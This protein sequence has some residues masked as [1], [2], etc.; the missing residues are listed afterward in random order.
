[1]ACA[2]ELYKV[3]IPFILVEKEQAVGGLAKTYK[4]GKFRT[5]NGPHRFY[6]QNKYLYDFIEDLVQEKWI[7]VNRFTRFYIKGKF[8]KYPVEILEI[9]KKIGFVNIVLILNDYAWA[10]VI[11]FR[12]K[13][14]NF[15]Q[16][17]LLTFGKRLAYLNVINFS[18]KTWGVSTEELSIDFASQRIKGVTIANILKT[19]LTNKNAVKSMIDQ[20]YYPS[21]GSGYVYECIKKRIQKDNRVEL[22]VKAQKIFTKDKQISKVLLSNGETVQI[23]NLVS[24]MPITEFVQLL[25]IPIPAV[26][27]KAIKKLRYR[28]QVYLFLTLNKPQVTRDQWIYFPDS[29]I[30][31]SRISEMKNFSKEMAPPNKTS[32]FVEYFCWYDD[33]V[34]NMSKKELSQLTISWLV[35]LGFIKEKDVISTYL[36]KQKDCYPV[37]DLNYQTNLQAIKNFLDQFENLYYIG[38]P[39]RFKYTNQ[40]HSLEMGIIAAR[41]I[42]D[43][44]RYDIE[45]V[46]STFEYFE[47]GNIQ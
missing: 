29:E 21:L 8:Y 20:F 34:W 10:S 6:S 46:G 27:Q 35:K 13:P 44:K 32:L 11:R 30:P 17:A 19:F 47:K 22:N 7:K 4:F 15:K 5:D 42:I 14:K 26:V 28:S 40:D 37:Y 23:K 33:E 2:M 41:S 24:S 25:D 12:I 9:I 45:H 36:L 1:M 18:E 31:F 3:N 38:R 16:Y 43:G 39:G